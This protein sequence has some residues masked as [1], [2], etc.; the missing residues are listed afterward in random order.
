MRIILVTGSVPPEA[1][2]IG[3]YTV[4]LADALNEIGVRAEILTGADWSGRGAARL[5]SAFNNRTGDF[6]H[7]QYPSV[8]YGHHLGPQVLSILRPTIVTVHEFG[9]V[10]VPRRIATLPFFIRSD[11]LI[12]TSD[13]ELK[14]VAKVVPGIGRKSSVIAIGSNIMPVRTP[15]P[16]RADRV[17]SFGLISPRKGLESVLRL[18]EILQRA[19]SRIRIQMVGALPEKHRG[20]AQ[21]FLR[22]A[23]G[24]PVDCEIDLP[25]QSVA[26]RL[27][28]AGVA[29]LPFPDG[30]SDRRG[31]LKAVLASGLPCVTTSGDYTPAELASVVRFA[32]SPEQACSV[33]EHLA[34]NPP[35][36]QEMSRAGIRYAQQFDWQS[37]ALKHKEVYEKVARRQRT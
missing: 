30:A 37:I 22:R 6:I 20:Y 33:I 19:G 34:G 7:I 35:E 4:R 36:C 5:N 8:G 28:E 2:G 17:L 16:R 32:P 18:A 24:L 15:V 9:H 27:A 3:H 25:E 14:T 31:S 29:Y 1:C 10:R 26:D 23:A 21:E 12:F 13:A 11:H